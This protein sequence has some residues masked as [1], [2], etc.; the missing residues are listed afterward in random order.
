MFHPTSSQFIYVQATT[1]VAVGLLLPEG[2]IDQYYLY[3]KALD[4]MDDSQAYGPLTPG[5]LVEIHVTSSCGTYKLTTGIIA[6]FYSA[7]KTVQVLAVPFNG[8]QQ[9]LVTES[10]TCRFLNAKDDLVL[11]EGYETRLFSA[12]DSSFYRR[13]RYG[14][15]VL[16]VNIKRLRVPKV[17]P[18]AQIY[19][20]LRQCIKEANPTLWKSVKRDFR[21]F[22]PTKVVPGQS[23][24]LLQTSY[25]GLCGVYGIIQHENPGGRVTFLFEFDG[26]IGSSDVPASY[27][28]TTFDV[29]DEVSGISITG[30]QVYGW[31]LGFKTSGHALVFDANAVSSVHMFF[32]ILAH[33]SC[34]GG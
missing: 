20:L 14:L 2:P 9:M 4:L 6:R 28:K 23:C 26:T 25:T 13:F 29:G 21:R 19:R 8:S 12:D 15:E 22:E 11:Q 31:I 30:S 5:T 10:T 34:V 18:G 33:G 1:A 27:L 16:N 3:P 24:K 17:S 32:T 7:A